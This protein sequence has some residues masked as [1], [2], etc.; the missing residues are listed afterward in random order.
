MAK[1]SKVTTADSIEKILSDPDFESN[2]DKLSFEDGLELLEQLVD[3]VESGTLPL[4]KSLGAYERGVG[5]VNRLRTLLNK[6]EEKL[7]IL[8]TSAAGEVGQE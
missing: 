4:D 1:S 2:L 7:K 6:A 8:D 3:R 5:V